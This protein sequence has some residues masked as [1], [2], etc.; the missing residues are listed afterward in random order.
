M[1]TGDWLFNPDPYQILQNTNSA[2]V[3]QELELGE[4]LTGCET[5]NKYHVYVKT[6]NNQNIYLFKCK[7]QSNWCD[8]NCCRYYK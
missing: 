8:R 5:P 4:L 7:E 3:Q 6:N 2:F 1:N